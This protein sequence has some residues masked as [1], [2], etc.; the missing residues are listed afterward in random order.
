[1]KIIDVD[2]GVIG[3]GIVG[4]YLAHRLKS[5]GERVALVDC[6]PP[7][8]TAPSP[9]FPPVIAPLRI[10]YGI[11]DGRH[12]EL[13]GNS[14]YWGGAMLRIPPEDLAGILNA[15]Q[16]PAE[17][18]AAAYGRVESMLHFPHSSQRI[19]LQSGHMQIP[20]VQQ[21]AALVLPSAAKHFFRSLIAHRLTEFTSL[22]GTRVTSLEVQAGRIRSL[23]VQDPAGACTLIRADR[24]FLTMGVVDSLLFAMKFQAELFGQTPP[25]L[26]RHLHDHLSTP[27]FR[28]FSDRKGTFLK[29]MVPHFNRGFLEVPR[30]E[31]TSSGTWGARAF[32]H[33]VFDFDSVA[34]YRDIKRLMALRQARSAPLAMAKQAINIARHV[35]ELSQIGFHRFAAN[36]LHVGADVPVTAVL[37][38]ESFPHRDNHLVSPADNDS[39]AAEMRWDIR[40]EDQAAFRDLFPKVQLLLESLAQEHRFSMQPCSDF[41]TEAALNQHLLRTAKDILH[42]GGGLQSLGGEAR[43]VLSADLSFPSA[44]N[45]QVVSTASLARGSVANPTHSLLAIAEFLA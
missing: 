19:P 7:P 33:F 22:F 42:L 16:F 30:F 31:L 5:K 2:S 21:T 11:T 37:D 32:V 10:H 41:S 9:P 38:F 15:D 43:S 4:S 8:E 34:V 20:D 1:M 36:R 13:G 40:T 26:A 39:A 6:G 12:H 17:G 35:G 44:A 29:Q 18:L 14:A 27:L 24:F 3:C 23:T 45:F 28:I 25:G